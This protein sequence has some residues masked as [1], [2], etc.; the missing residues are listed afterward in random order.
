MKRLARQRV[1]V[2]IHFLMKMKM[3]KEGGEKMEDVREMRGK[4]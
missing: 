1:I 3:H 4:I 2:M